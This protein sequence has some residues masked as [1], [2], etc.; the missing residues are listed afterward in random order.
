MG[1]SLE[2]IVVHS[3]HSS[4]YKEAI[5]HIR[6]LPFCYHSREHM[7]EILALAPGDRLADDCPSWHDTGALFSWPLLHIGKEPIRSTAY[8][9]LRIE[10]EQMKGAQAWEMPCGLLGACMIVVVCRY[11]KPW[12]LFWHPYN[13]RQ[14]VESEKESNVCYECY[15]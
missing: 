12:Y 3:P 13:W 2:D 15:H 6:C 5:Q 9:W 8:I 10:R 7:I 4:T 14:L 1:L 11:K